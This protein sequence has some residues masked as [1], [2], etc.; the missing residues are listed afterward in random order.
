MRVSYIYHKVKTESFDKTPIFCVFGW[1]NTQNKVI[2]AVLHNNI[3]LNSLKFV[4]IDKVKLLILFELYGKIL[5]LDMRWSERLPSKWRLAG[6]FRGVCPF[7]GRSNYQKHC[8]SSCGTVRYS[9]GP[10]YSEQMLMRGLFRIFKWASRKRTARCWLMVV[11]PETQFA[12]VCE[13]GFYF[14]GRIADKRILKRRKNRWQS[15]RRSE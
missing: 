12:T 2:L 7:I 10:E 11:P 4:W 14:A 8:R 1:K 9:W 3:K 5:R 13:Y 15:M 6:N